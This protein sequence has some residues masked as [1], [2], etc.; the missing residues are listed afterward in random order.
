[1]G[2]L[3]HAVFSLPQ[4]CS[5]SNCFN[6]LFLLELSSGYSSGY[7]TS[8]HV[9]SATEVQKVCATIESNVTF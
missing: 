7:S 1:M 6:Y 9:D 8:R 3:G 5:I 4:D 2:C